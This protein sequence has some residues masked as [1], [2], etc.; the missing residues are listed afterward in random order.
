MSTPQQIFNLDYHPS[1]SVIGAASDQLGRSG[2]DGCPSVMSLD[3][4]HL[5]CFYMHRDQAQQVNPVVELLQEII[6][7]CKIALMLYHQKQQGIE[8]S[9]MDTVLFPFH[10]LPIN[11]EGFL[12][13][14]PTPMVSG[15][16]HPDTMHTAASSTSDDSIDRTPLDLNTNPSDGQQHDDAGDSSSKRQDLLSLYMRL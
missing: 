11:P 15:I 6:R 2:S 10:S 14:V 7:K 8:R 5:E 12:Q 9:G 4:G 1:S 3:A 13:S 16:S